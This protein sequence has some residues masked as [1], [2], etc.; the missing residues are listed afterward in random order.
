MYSL[1]TPVNEVAFAVCDTETTGT[2]SKMMELLEL[3]AVAIDPPLVLNL[4]NSFESLVKPEAPIPF[5]ATAIHGIT[6]G[7]ANEAPDAED[8]LIKFGDYIENRVLVFH[9]A[10]FDH[11]VLTRAWKKCKIQPPKMQ[12]LDTLTIS[13]KVHRNIA[14]HSLDSLIELYGLA[15]LRSGSGRHRALYDSDMTAVIFLQ[16]LQKLQS[17]RSMTLYDLFAL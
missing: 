9:N 4:H 13:R 12:I 14:S 1:D 6:D 3:A 10:R 5:A 8:V 2:T 15:P 17:E 7:M 11:N 16:M